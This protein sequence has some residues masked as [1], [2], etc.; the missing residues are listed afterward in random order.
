MTPALTDHRLQ[1]LHSSCMYRLYKSS[2]C[3]R[4]TKLVSITGSSRSAGETRHHVNE[5]FTKDTAN[6]SFALLA[7]K[8]NPSRHSI[9]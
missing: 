5:S 6:R 9:F 8:L 1:R 3:P 7:S 2:Q 4:L